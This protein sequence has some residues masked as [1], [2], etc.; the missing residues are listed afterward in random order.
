[1][2]FALREL[3]LSSDPVKKLKDLRDKGTLGDLEP[4]LAA[5][6]MSIPKGYHH[7]D[8]LEH[9][10]QVLQNAID[11]E[12]DGVDLVLR[13]AALFHDIG[14]P[15][16]REFGDKGVVTFTNHDVVGAKIVRKVLPRH[17]YS[18][19]EVDQ[20]GRLVYMHMRSHTFA[21]GWTDSAVRRLIT[22]AG[23]VHQLERLIVVFYADTTTKIPGKKVN[24]HAKVA[25]LS[26]E[27]ARVDKADKRASLRPALNGLE[28][29]EFLNIKPG[30]EL[31][32]AMKLL[33]SDAHVGL[34]KEASYALLKETF[35]S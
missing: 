26:D 1:M 4:T 5:L 17:G 30:P 11:R 35:L 8:N 24:L 12:V 19:A 29:A 20:I 21:S 16:T 18:K 28:V 25:A 9:S 27:L 22:D 13:T 10:F 33:N 34:D 15:A 23:S 32:R 2:T 14:K 6:K 31:G 3:L 7:K